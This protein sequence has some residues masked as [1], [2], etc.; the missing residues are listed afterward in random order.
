MKIDRDSPEWAAIRDHIAARL[1]ELATGL[2]SD[3]KPKAFRD[4]QARIREL[5]DLIRHVE[6]EQI[7]A[8]AVIDFG[9]G[10]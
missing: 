6:P 8:D 7:D 3:Q 4:K 10:G 1:S 9:L 5:Q 2:L